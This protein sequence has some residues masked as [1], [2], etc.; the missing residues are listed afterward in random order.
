[1]QGFDAGEL[2]RRAREAASFSYSPY[3]HFPVGAALL[4]DDGTIV[5]GANV[6]NRSFGLA[7]CAERS[8]LFAAVS[9]GKTR[10]VALAVV[11]S[12]AEEPVSPCGACRQ[13]L[14]EFCPPGMPVI[15]QGRDGEPVATT[16]GQLLPQD[17]LH[18]LKDGL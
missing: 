14:S 9:Q 10:F 2:L 11:C 13:A 3:S 16:M 6:E 1:M 17:A 15:Y 18:D 12:R 8:A 7:N 4:C 5:T